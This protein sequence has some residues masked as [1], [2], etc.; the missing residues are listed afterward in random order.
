MEIL[1]IFMMAELLCAHIFHDF[2]M[3]LFCAVSVIG[4]LT[5]DVAH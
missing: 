2:M 3:C 4:H 1:F 5:V